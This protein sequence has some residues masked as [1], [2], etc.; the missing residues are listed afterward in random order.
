MVVL[1][2]FAGIPEVFW[3]T[4]RLSFSKNLAYLPFVN[5]FSSHPT[6]YNIS[7]V[8]T[9]PISNLKINYF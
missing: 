5:I 6:L 8:Q 3:S 4:E 2:L 1:S 7:A 9:P